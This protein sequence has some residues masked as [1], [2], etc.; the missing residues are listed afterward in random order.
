MFHCSECGKESIVSL[1]IDTKKLK[2]I[3]DNKETIDEK[4]VNE[5]LKDVFS[6]PSLYIKKEREK[7]MK[8][9]RKK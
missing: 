1:N 3:F 9:M 2:K 4:D 6:S 8:T 7:F 5:M